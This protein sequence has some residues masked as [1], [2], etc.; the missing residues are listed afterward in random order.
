MKAVVYSTRPFE[1]EYL[2]KAN[3]KKHDITL[4]SNALGS[5]TI[6]YATGKKAII[7]YSTDNVSASIIAQLAMLGT[8]FIISRLA[9]TDFIDQEAASAYQIVVFGMTAPPPTTAEEHYGNVPSPQLIE[10]SLQENANQIVNTLDAVS[11]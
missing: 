9:N 1:R 6:G 4:I 11:R 5:D 2:A 8:K 10:V 3:S 7:V